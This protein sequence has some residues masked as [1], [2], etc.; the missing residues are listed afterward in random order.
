MIGLAALQLALTP[1]APQPVRLDHYG[2][3]ESQSVRSMVTCDRQRTLVE[4]VADRNGVRLLKSQ[5]GRDA[6]SQARLTGLGDEL[7]RLGRLR[8]WRVACFGRDAVILF[9]GFAQGSSPVVIETYHGLVND[10]SDKVPIV[11]Q[12]AP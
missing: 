5:L 1:A 12:S 6:A 3:P 8:A 10:Y 4:F 9:R 7:S 11:L 2:A